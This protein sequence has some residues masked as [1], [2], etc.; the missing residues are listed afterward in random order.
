ML[1][2]VPSD[3]SAIV[4]ALAVVQFFT[5]VAKQNLSA[6]KSLP[7]TKIRPSDDVEGAEDEDEVPARRHPCHACTVLVSLRSLQL[8]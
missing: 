7:A 6:A 8:L 3:V 4:S 2:F 5:A 1:S